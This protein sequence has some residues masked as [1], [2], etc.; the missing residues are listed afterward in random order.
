LHL[1]QGNLVLTIL[2]IVRRITRLGESVNGMIPD[3]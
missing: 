1:T 3:P 2:A